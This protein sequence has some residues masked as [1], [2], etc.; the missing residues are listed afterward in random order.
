MVGALV[1]FVVFHIA[2]I[3]QTLLTLLEFGAT[4]YVIVARAVIIFPY[5]Y[6]YIYIYIYKVAD[7]GVHD[8]RY[9]PN[10]GSSSEDGSF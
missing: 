6:I 8:T 3:L 4:L 7:C 9:P 2:V 1:V 10:N 5:I